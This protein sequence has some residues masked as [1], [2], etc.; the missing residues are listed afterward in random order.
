MKFIKYFF[1]IT[2]LLV[3]AAGCKKEKNDDVSFLQTDTAPKALSALF[4]ITQDNTGLVTIT[5]NGESIS[6]YEIFYGD[7]TTDPVSVLPGKNIQHVYPEGVFNVKIVGHSITGKVTEATQ[8]LTVA[9]RAPEDL[10]FTAVIDAANNFKVN[11]SATAQYETFFK[12]YFG[13]D[14]NEVPAS[15]LEGETVSHTYAATGTFTVKVIAYSGGTAVTELTKTVTIVDPVL[16]PLT[17]ESPTINYSFVNF[18]GGDVTAIANPQQNGIN[19]SAKVGRMVKNAPEVWGGSFISLS[20]PINFSANKIF[21]MKVFSPRVGA[22]VLLKVE[23]A[24]DGN[25]AYEK[26]ATCTVAN[27]WEDLAF[28]YTAINTANSYHKVVLIFDLGTAG[29][30]SA[31]FT[32]LFDDIRLTNTL[33]S[34]FLTLP[35]T[36]DDPAITYS[37]T[38]FGNTQTVNDVDPTNSSNKVKKTTKPNGAET[39][40]GTTLSPGFQTALPFSATATQMSVRVYSPAAGIRIRFK[41]EDRA[42][43]TRSVETEAV[44]TVANAWETL[45]FD[46]ANQAP[47]T[48]ALNLSF[49][50]NLASIFFEFGTAGN[51]KVFYWDDVK[52]LPANVAG[53]AL[54]LDFQ[55]TT[56]TYTFTGFGRANAAVID[57]PDASGINTS[58]KVG[59]LTKDAGSE[60]WAGSFIE[61]AAPIDFSSLTKIKMKVW[62]PAAGITVKFKMENLADANINTERDAVTTVANAWEELTYDFSGIVNS[63]NYQRVVVFF[64]FGNAGTGAN[65][66]FDDIKLSN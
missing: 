4:T 43:N 51:G 49:T 25:I 21:R 31:N 22:K 11:V 55:S 48:A 54:P 24:T 14:P 27:A 44:S 58:T 5:P 16:L 53:V 28:D 9:F 12:V 46:F 50:F 3:L 19:T 15:F 39:W 20:E 33:P 63:N 42:D 18:G 64:D 6:Y 65:Y 60:T 40:A 8:Q 10:D 2:F 17:F 61:M 66:Y 56:L 13:E 1:S 30:G 26:E 36:F 59:A 7:A 35:V 23:N 38:D 45:V 47:G 41:V 57:N 62:S 52:F 32:F 29:D 37:T 34:A